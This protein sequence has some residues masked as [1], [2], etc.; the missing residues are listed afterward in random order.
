MTDGAPA[1]GDGEMGRVVT[2]L[3]MI[4]VLLVVIAILLLVILVRGPEDQDR[5]AAPP[6][7]AIATTG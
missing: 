6:T 1:T 5:S 2:L 3:Q 4:T 7:V